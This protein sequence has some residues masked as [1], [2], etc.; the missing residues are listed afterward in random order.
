MTRT[1]GPT[2]LRNMWCAK[3]IDIKL[4]KFTSSDEEEFSG[5]NNLS[6]N[7]LSESYILHQS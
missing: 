7:L 1:V 6:I 3:S 2:I 4:M 5:R